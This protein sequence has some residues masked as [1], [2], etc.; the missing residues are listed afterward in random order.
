MAYQIILRHT[1]NLFNFWLDKLELK[2][3][4]DETAED[5]FFY[6]G[7]QTDEN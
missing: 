2:D 5:L 6:H 1:E 4:I 7:S 3:L